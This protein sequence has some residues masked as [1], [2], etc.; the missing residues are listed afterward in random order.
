MKT[1]DKIALLYFI[2]C[3]AL[4]GFFAILGYG[5]NGSRVSILET[6]GYFCF[7][8]M[9]LLTPGTVVFLLI[10]MIKHFRLHIL[11]ALVVMLLLIWSYYD[12]YGTFLPL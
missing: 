6:I 11:M 8:T 10:D 7:N 3:I 1:S 9:W 2:V 4:A 5:F 12:T